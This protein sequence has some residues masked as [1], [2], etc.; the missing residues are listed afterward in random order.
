L[1]ASFSD[2]AFARYGGDYKTISVAWQYSW[3]D[4]PASHR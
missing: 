2:G 3:L 1:K 4:A